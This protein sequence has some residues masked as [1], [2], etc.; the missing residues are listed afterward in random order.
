MVEPTALAAKFKKRFGAAPQIYRAPGRVNLIGDHTDY[1]Q[2]FV[3]PAAIEFSCYAAISRSS[4]HQMTLFSENL[5][6][7]LSISI[8][9]QPIA[10][11]GQW[12]DYAAGV[13]LQIQN[14]G[15][16]LG[17]ANL[18]IC[19]EVP[20]GA[21]LS[22]SAAFEVST[23]CALL[24]I[25]GHKAEPSQIAKL[26]QK[27]E[28][29]FVGAQC[30]IM[31]QFVACN[32]LRDHALLL[33]C[34][35]LKFQAVPI[36]NYLRIVICNTMVEH[37]LAAEHNEYN[38]RRAECEEAVRLLAQAMPQV[39]TLRDL[40]LADLDQ[41][42]GLLTGKLYKRCRHVVSENGRVEQMADALQRN[43]MKQSRE[44]MA[45]SHRSLRDDYEV[46]CAELDLLVS[47]AEQQ[48]GVHGARM[49]GAGFGGCTVNLVEGIY[50][51]EFRRRVAE[52]YLAQTGRHSEIY[53]CKAAAGAGRAL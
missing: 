38:R 34:R 36:P 41:H 31:D 5:E 37:K 28:N 23:A 2:G 25:F 24:G 12:S 1:N 10:R 9:E 14:A 35:S 17:G 13:F 33:D 47:V 7:T 50:V 30:G 22:S 3:L 29:E 49:T 15:Y 42:R 45:E 32:G 52:Q 39:R 27:A 11:S 48:K 4:N 53:V 20:I 51:E 8:N 46:S 43:D 16:P 19:S 6:D 26:C 18:Y 21:G 44:L 40:S